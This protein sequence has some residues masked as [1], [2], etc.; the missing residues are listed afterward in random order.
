MAVMTP[1]MLAG[2]IRPILGA[3]FECRLA[4]LYCR[5]ELRGTRSLVDNDKAPMLRA[6]PCAPATRLIA[7]AFSPRARKYFAWLA[8][9]APA[10]VNGIY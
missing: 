2:K 3:R 10:I 7:A 5:A 9:K 6:K 8:R 4:S 1:G